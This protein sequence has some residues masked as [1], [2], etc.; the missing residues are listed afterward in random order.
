MYFCCR[1]CTSVVEVATPRTG[2]QG[3]VAAITD[4]TSIPRTGKR[5]SLYC[6]YT[7]WVILFVAAVVRLLDLPPST[8]LF[9]V[10]SG[11]EIFRLQ[12]SRIVV[13]LL[14]TEDRQSMSHVPACELMYGSH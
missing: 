6:V 1:S 13:N 11:F 5:E 14:A 7:E 10:G 12:F 4:R 3:I 2:D 8:T 9:V